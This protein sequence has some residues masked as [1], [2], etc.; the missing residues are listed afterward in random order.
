M[1]RVIPTSG[2]KLY[3]SFLIIISGL[4]LYIDLNHKS[5]EGIKTFINPLLFHQ[6]ILLKAQQLSL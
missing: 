5:F 2:T 3:I 4:F 1:S 6:N